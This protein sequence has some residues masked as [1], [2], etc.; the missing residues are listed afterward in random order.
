M[1]FAFSGEQS[2][3]MQE[4]TLLLVATTISVSM[5]ARFILDDK[6]DQLQPEI[7]DMND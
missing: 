3:S 4:S 1:D 2:P 5:D 6:A 7:N